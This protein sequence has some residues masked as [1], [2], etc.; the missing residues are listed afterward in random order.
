MKLACGV[1]VDE[2]K[3]VSS[4]SFIFYQEIEANFIWRA[5]C[6]IFI[7]LAEDTLIFFSLSTKVKTIKFSPIIFLYEKFYLLEA[8]LSNSLD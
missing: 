5:E 2:I 3:K 8:I 6:V 4:M 1:Y 7:S